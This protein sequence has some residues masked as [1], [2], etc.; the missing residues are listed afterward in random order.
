[1]PEH[2][3]PAA[4]RTR[5]GY[6]PERTDRSRRTRHPLRRSRPPSLPA[7]RRAAPDLRD[8]L[9]QHRPVGRVNPHVP[10]RHSSQPRLLDHRLDEG[11]VAQPV[12]IE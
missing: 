2:T 4:I 10:R 7:P 9:A 8:H 6:A 5:G 11:G 12:G 1:M 3:R